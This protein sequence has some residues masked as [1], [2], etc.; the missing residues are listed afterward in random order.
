MNGREQR[1]AFTLLII[2]CS[3]LALRCR[4]QAAEPAYYDYLRGMLEE[5]AGNLTNALSSYERAV[6]QDPEAIEVFRDI[7]QVSLRLGQNDAAL[8]AAE[9]VRDLAPKDPS[10][11]IFIGN[12]HVA[13]GNLA[14]AAQSYQKALDLEPHNLRALENLGNYYAIVDPIKALDYYERYLALD[15]HDPE[16]LF[17]LGMVQHKVGQTNRAIA[18]LKKSLQYDSRQPAPYL[19]LAEIYEVQKSTADAIAAFE[20]AA[21]LQPGHPLIH[22]RLAQLY[23]VQK[24]LPDAYRHY[25]ISQSANPKDPTNAYWL[26]RIAEDQENWPLAAQHAKEAYNVSRD[27]QFLPLLAYYLTL[28]RQP[29]EAITWLEKA[30]AKTPQNPNVLLFLGLNYLELGKLEKAKEALVK[31]VDVSSGDAQIQFQLGVT[32]D[33]LNQFEKAVSSFETAIKLDPSNAAAMNYLGYS[34]AE[35]A[36]RLSEAD[37]LLQKA[38]ALDPQNGAYLDS[39]GWL[40][41][42]QGRYGEAVEI[43]EKASKIT[44]DKLIHDHLKLAQTALVSAETSGSDGR[45]LLTNIEGNLRQI[46]DMRSRVWVDARLKKQPFKLKGLLFYRRP[47][48]LVV[49]VPGLSNMPDIRLR[50]SGAGVTVEPA[51]YAGALTPQAAG[52]LQVLPRFFSGAL[53]SSFDHPNVDTKT[54]KQLVHYKSRTEEAWID[55]VS[56]VLTRWVQ[57]NPDGGR[58]EIDIDG[59]AQIDGLWL[60]SKMRLRNRQRGFEALVKFSDWVV[61]QPD[62]QIPFK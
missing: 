22:S 54:E 32:Y 57:S 36:E 9:R 15:I 41:F 35:R 44:P 61:N 13:Q 1:T 20:S 14:K 49:E 60:P 37:T 28:N 52:G 46:A 3:L 56:G 17:Q 29:A 7:A 25:Q 26:S 31:G 45:K 24:N 6:T 21:A 33:R 58:D 43:L 8:R 18:T 47:D 16:M 11:F 12:V 4:T 38:V 59:Y 23:Y 42:K 40:R 55:P 34:W 39:L 19:A 2:L 51:D 30:R 10:S 27:P 48:D 62:N 50:V 53:T 5:R